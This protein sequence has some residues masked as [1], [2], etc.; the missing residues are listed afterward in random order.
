MPAVMK[1]LTCFLGRDRSSGKSTA[2]AAVTAERRFV[3][4]QTAF[5]CPL[6][7]NAGESGL[8]AQQRQLCVRLTSARARDMPPRAGCSRRLAF[9]ALAPRTLIR[10]TNVTRSS[11]HWSRTPRVSRVCAKPARRREE[12]EQKEK[13]KKKRK[14]KSMKRK[15]SPLQKTR[16]LNFLIR[17]SPNARAG[18]AIQSLFEGASC[19]LEALS[20]LLV[21]SYPASVRR[22]PGPERPLILTSHHIHPPSGGYAGKASEIH[23]HHAR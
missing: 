18:K 23:S 21:K 7:S 10:A 15:P 12:K 16:T 6:T 19:F 20:K 22:P 17:T 11:R 1:E 5:P 13:R 4:S 2:A 3:A 8:K 9:K 14:T